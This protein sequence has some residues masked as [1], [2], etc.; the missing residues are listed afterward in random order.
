MERH[1]PA[2]RPLYGIGSP[3]GIDENKALLRR[4]HDEMNA[5][6]LAAFDEMMHPAFRERNNFAEGEITAVQSKGLM[7]AMLSAFPDMHRTV[8]TQVAEGD[9]VVDVLTYT[10]T[11]RGDFMG[12]PPTGKTATIAS[13]M[14]SR[15]EDGRIIEI[16]AIVDMLSLMQQLGLLPE[17][18]G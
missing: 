13:T 6:N 15:V 16:W 9:R 1:D 11:H 12:A 14:I 8:V 7:A 4:W 5:H 10:A 2:G 17:G 3:V 18:A